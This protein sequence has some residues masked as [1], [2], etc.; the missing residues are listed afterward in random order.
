MQD[1]ISDTVSNLFNRIILFLS[2]SLPQTMRSVVVINAALIASA[3]AGLI[4]TDLS[5]YVNDIEKCE[6]LCWEKTAS[7]ISCSNTDFNCV[8]QGAG[9]DFIEEALV[10]W[11][12]SCNG[13]G[14]E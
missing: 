11:S 5:D 4:F 1:G 13:T 6:L 14:G 9:M 12:N 2:V 10:C 3:Q 8:C 7:E